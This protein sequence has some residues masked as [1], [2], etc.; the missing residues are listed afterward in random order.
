VDILVTGG[1][2]FLGRAV[3]R[4]LRQAGH[5]VTV[6]TRRQV[7]GRAGDGVTLVQDDLTRE[8]AI[9][10]LIGEGGFDG[11]CHLAGLT[12]I[13]DSFGRPAEYFDVN[14]GGTVNLLKAVRAR[15][16]RTGE[17]TR[18]VF[19]SSRA[20]Y[21]DTADAPA[22]ETHPAVPTTPYGVTKRAAE[23]L[24]GFESLLGVT[25][26]VA[27]RCF[28]ISGGAPGIVD[29]DTRRLVPR[30][31]EAL[32]G[33]QPP[34]PLGAGGTRLDLVHVADVAH[35]FALALDHA[36][37]GEFRIYNVGSG[38][39]IP[40]ED[41]VTLLERSAGRSLPRQPG[42]GGAANHGAVTADVSLIRRELGWAPAHDAEAI[43]R[44]AW[45]FAQPGLLQGSC[46]RA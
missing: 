26:A 39:S 21:A 32:A 23:Q 35:A 11:V 40:L 16:D 38:T 9:A 1:L 2:G 30:L 14:V 37:P 25:G 13:R 28:N 3:V 8:G 22:A 43:M 45:T 18:I 5:R 33:R 41:V 36:A 6:L 31:V 24:L 34:P 46:P 15:H 7:S 44:D 19:A 29:T 27:L 42:A 4:K 10:G 20:V 12:G 17:A